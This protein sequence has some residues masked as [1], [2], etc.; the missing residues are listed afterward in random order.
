MISDGGGD[1]RFAYENVL[2]Q[3]EITNFDGDFLP[4][5]MNFNII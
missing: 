5:R 3:K 4:K 2:G 1:L